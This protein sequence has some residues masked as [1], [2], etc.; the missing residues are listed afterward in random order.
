[1]HTYQIQYET[2]ATETYNDLE[3]AE[4]EA[5]AT[6]SLPAVVL[7]ESTHL[8]DGNLSATCWYVYATQADA[9][10]DQGGRSLARIVEVQ[11]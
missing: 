9:D 2:R 7:A 3:T 10:A 4:R 5:A 6:L 11:S 8:V 1:M